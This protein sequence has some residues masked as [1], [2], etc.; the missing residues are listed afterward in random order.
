MPLEAFIAY[1]WRRVSFTGQAVRQSTAVAKKTRSRSDFVAHREGLLACYSF[2]RLGL[3]RN[4]FSSLSG[5][6][7]ERVST[8]SAQRADSAH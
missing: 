7:S 2:N 8:Y 3:S 6:P 5:I 4:R 1:R